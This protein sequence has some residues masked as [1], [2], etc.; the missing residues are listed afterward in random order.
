MREIL[1]EIA[2]PH[3]KHSFLLKR[4]TILIK[5][6][7][8]KAEAQLLDG[9][10]FM[11]RCSHCDTIFSV[12][13]PFLFR[14]PRQYSLV[15]SRNDQMGR[16]EESEPLYRCSDPV[17]F[18]EWYRCLVYGVDP[19]YFEQVKAR[20]LKQRAGSVEFESYDQEQGLFWFWNDGQLIAIKTKENL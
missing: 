1:F 11:H 9:S 4:D 3:C 10:Y 8:S 12:F 16:F 2:C 20:L 15:L 7:N 6:M 19:S 5:G 18:I 13:H 17:T 14:N